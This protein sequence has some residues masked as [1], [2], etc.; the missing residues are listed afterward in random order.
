MHATL[1]VIIVGL[2]YCS[3]NDVNLADFRLQCLDKIFV[4]GLKDLLNTE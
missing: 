2:F 1:S 4:Q 3:D